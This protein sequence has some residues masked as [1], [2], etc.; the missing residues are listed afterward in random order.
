MGWSSKYEVISTKDL[1]IGN[2][3]PVAGGTNR[4][5]SKIVQVL[6][7]NAQWNPLQVAVN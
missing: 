3:Y 2:T 6:H 4:L 1:L 5:S 7:V